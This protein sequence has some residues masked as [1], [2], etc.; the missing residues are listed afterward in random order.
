[1]S[2][3]N[4]LWNLRESLRRIFWR[5]E[6]K[7]DDVVSLMEDLRRFCRADSPTLM[8]DKEGRVDPI[9]SAMLEGRR[10]VYLRL[11]AKLNMTDEQIRLIAETKEKEE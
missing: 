6:Y 4:K 5:N 11:Q 3:Y 7:D 9:A 8:F 10:E 1:M 2:I